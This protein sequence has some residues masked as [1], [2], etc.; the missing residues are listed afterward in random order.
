MAAPQAT[1]QA[2]ASSALRNLGIQGIQYLDQMS[3]GSGEG[4]KNFV[5]FDP[6]I[7]EIT[8]K[9]GLAGAAITGSALRTLVPQEENPPL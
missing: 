3:R 2:A 8:K 5:L 4:T 6:K 1:S 9:Y 7:A